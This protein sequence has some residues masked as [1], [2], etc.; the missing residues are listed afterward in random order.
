MKQDLSAQLAQLSVHYQPIVDL[1]S[2]AVA[3]CEA[4]ARVSDG[5]GATCSIGPIIE[6]VENDPDL[7]ELLMRQLLGVIHR[8]AVPLFERYPD[9]YVSVNVPPAILGTRKIRGVLDELDLYPYLNRL[10]CE[11]T[12]RQALTDA[13]RAALDAAREYHI[14]LALDDFGTGNSGIAQ[15]LGMKVDL[16]KLDRSQVIQLTKSHLAERLVRGIIA[17]AAIIRARVVAEGVETPAQALFLQATG[18]DYAQGWF[19]S[20]AVPAAELPNIIET[21]YPNWRSDLV[22]RLNDGAR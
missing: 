3:G 13:G 1:N 2:G 18:V 21:G 15:L 10:V 6:S 11:V 14:R 7:L 20:A 17:L 5:K 16:L 9:F 19:W 4:L 8:E 12:E 22:D